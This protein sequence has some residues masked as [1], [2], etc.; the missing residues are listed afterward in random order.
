MRRL[1]EIIACVGELSAQ[2]MDQARARQ[3]DLTKPPGSL[4]RLEALHVQ[5]AGITGIVTPQLDQ[6]A[7]IVMAGDHGVAVEGVSAYPAEVTPQMVLNF[8]RGGAAIN[9]LA[10]AAG[11]RVVIV[12]AGVATELPALPAII[13]RPV[14][15]GT[16]NMASGPAMSRE[17]AIQSLELGIDILEQ[18]R[19]RGLDI[20]ATGDMGI[21]NT[22]ASAA[23]V[24]ALT[25]K[26]VADVTGRGT[27]IDD[28]GWARKVRVIE[29][30]LAINRPDP[31]DP[32]DVL[33]KVGGFEIGGLAGV[34][35]AAAAAR[36]PVV[37][38]GFISGAAALVAT[39]LCPAVRRFMIAAHSSVEVGHRI[40][41]ERLELSPLLQL[42][43]RL[44]EGTGAALALPIIDAALRIPR[45]MATF[46]EAGVSQQAEAK[47]SEVR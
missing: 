15:R 45:D 38:D 11:A 20:V 6:K 36:I 46:S 34:M 44:G 37:I 42:D 27:G 40:I 12:N 21:G 25:G 3:L 32:L 28:V 13:D 5:I 19:L 1:E 47:G 29:R 9:V 16:A 43:L 33:A 41:L 8:V 17:Q 4:G 10:D 24:A 30:A 7:V 18:E 39:E 14:A 23:V 2:A 22:T 26:A 31:G 35:L